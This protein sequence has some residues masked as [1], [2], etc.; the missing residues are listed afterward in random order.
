MQLHARLGVSASD[1]RPID[2]IEKISCP[3]FLM[4]GENDRNTRQED[5][6][7]LFSHA[8]SPKQLW[9]VPNAAHVDLHRAATEEYESRVLAFLNQM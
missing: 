7:M 9:F 3:I 1:L 6:R 4:S 8:Q 2:H 5:T